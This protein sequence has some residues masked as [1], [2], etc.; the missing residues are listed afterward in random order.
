MIDGQKLSEAELQAVRDGP[1][2]TNL[3]S[4]SE[5]VSIDLS[6][7][8]SRFQHCFGCLEKFVYSRRFVLSPPPKIWLNFFSRQGS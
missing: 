1:I 2:P 4:K 7:E 8:S 3:S 6:T 5:H